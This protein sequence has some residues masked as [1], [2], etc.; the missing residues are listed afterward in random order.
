MINNRNR[1]HAGLEKVVI[2]YQTDVKMSFFS[3]KPVAEFDKVQLN[4]DYTRNKRDFC[5]IRS[6]V[7][8]RPR[9]VSGWVLSR[10]KQRKKGLS[11]AKRACYPWYPA[12]D[13]FNGAG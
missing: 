8:G 13:Q 4:D 12:Y 2:A 11:E 9:E 10:I 1:S 7:L 3:D 6:N 5:S